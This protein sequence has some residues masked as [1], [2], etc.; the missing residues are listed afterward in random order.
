MVESYQKFINDNRPHLLLDVREKVQYDICSLPNSLHIPLRQLSRRVDEVKQAIESRQED[1]ELI[2]IFFFVCY[3]Y[4]CKLNVVT[5]MA[6]KFM[7]FA[8]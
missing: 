4:P 7:W 5:P 6:H 3:R 1:G 8:D 2:R